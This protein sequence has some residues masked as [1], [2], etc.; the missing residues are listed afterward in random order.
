MKK[1]LPLLL[2]LLGLCL[3]SHGQNSDVSYTG[4]LTTACTNSNTN[5]GNQ[6]AT[7][8]GAPATGS[9]LEV[10]SRNYVVSG[11]TVRGTYTGATINFE[12]SDDGGVTYFQNLCTRTDA[13]VQ[14]VSE[15]LPS[16]QTRAWDCGV[17]S[18]TNFRIRISAISTGTVQIGLTLST[19]SI[20]PA[21]T[22]SLSTAGLNAC[23]NQAVTLQSV[24]AATSGT[25]AT[26]IIAL[27]AGAKIY[28]CSLNVIGTSG[29]TPTFS[30]VYGTGSNCATGQNVLVNAFAT[31]AAVLYAFGNPVAVTP[32]GQAVCYLDTGTTPIQSYVI[33]FVQQ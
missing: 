20:E 14:E 24:S 8:G 5:C 33:G 6:V 4:T 28:I 27:A 21:P 11:V 19:A 23:S 12:F 7:E 3:P 32:V 10:S 1:L 26:Q 16:N 9:V 31:T 22:V 2:I 13:N 29:T 17:G 18:S 15:V 30:L 25:T